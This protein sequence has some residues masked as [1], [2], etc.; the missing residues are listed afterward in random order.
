MNLCVIGSRGGHIGYVFESIED[1]PELDLVAVTGGS[2]DDF[3]GLLKCAVEKGYSPKTYSDWKKM[4]NEQHPDLVAVDGPFEL[5]AEMAAYALERG[6]NVFCE[7]PIALTLSDLDRVVTAQRKSGAHIVS[8]AGLRYAP[9]FQHA[10]KLVREGAVGTVKLIGVRKSYKLGTRPDFY[11]KRATYG[12]TIPWVG[13]HAIDWIL[14]FSG[15]AFQCVYATQTTTDNFNHGELESA[16]LCL[17]TM[18]NG[19]QAQASVDYLRPSMAPTHGDDRIRVVGTKGVLEVADGKI[20][21]IDGHGKREIPVPTPEKKIFSDF[22]NRLLHD[23]DC[24]LNDAE[25]FEVTRA[26]LLARESAD[27]GTIQSF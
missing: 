16:A 21:L 24:L 13:S 9:A 4:L 3:A 8:M 23:S 6:I 15:S 26:C 1:V 10:L 12:G 14:A 17:F 27:T 25:T 5:H 18:K 11:R 2:G 7:K 19:V 22:V 20:M